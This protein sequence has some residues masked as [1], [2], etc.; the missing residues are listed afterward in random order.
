MHGYV[1]SCM[2]APL[3]GKSLAA[4]GLT[5]EIASF[6][7]T[8]SVY[9]IAIGCGHNNE[10][11]FFRAVDRNEMEGELM[12]AVIAW[13]INMKGPLYVSIF[14]SLMVVFVAIL[15]S[16]MLNENLHLGSVS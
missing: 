12:V 7:H 1:S 11:L 10:G 16:L 5:S 3:Y 13:C 6:G 2:E 9:R 15:S 4:L 14:S 8:G